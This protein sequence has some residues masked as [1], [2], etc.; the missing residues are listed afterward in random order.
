MDIFITSFLIPGLG[1]LTALFVITS[2]KTLIKS[3][4]SNFLSLVSSFLSILLIIA[5]LYYFNNNFF[6]YKE[7]KL[8]TEPEC[9]ELEAIIKDATYEESK[10][11]LYSSH[12]LLETRCNYIGDN[13][14]KVNTIEIWN[15]DDKE[16]EQGFKIGLNNFTYIFHQEPVGSWEII[17][18]EIV[19]DITLKHKVFDDLTGESFLIRENEKNNSDAL[20]RAQR[21]SAGQQNPFEKKQ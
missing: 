13:F 16:E 8:S 1:L 20:K 12:R 2:Y 6:S 14:A 15:I 4:L 10:K 18:K 19:E 9:S 3:S 21:K 5:S 17:S 7:V 11:N